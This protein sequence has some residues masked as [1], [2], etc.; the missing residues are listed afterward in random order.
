MGSGGVSE[1]D[2]CR[3]PGVIRKHWED[4]QY[5]FPFFLEFL[6]NKG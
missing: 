2:Y 3:I 5:N 4:L 6:L 1:R